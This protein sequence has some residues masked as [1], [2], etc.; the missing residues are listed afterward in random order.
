[1]TARLQAATSSGKPILLRVDFDAGHGFGSGR[2]QRNQLVADE[3]AFALWQ[4]GDP[5]QR[6]P[7]QAA[8]LLRSGLKERLSAT[9]GFGRL[10][11][12][13]CLSCNE[14]ETLRTRGLYRLIK[15]LAAHRRFRVSHKDFAQGERS[16]EIQSE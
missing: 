9:D 4:L 3:L 14:F 6:R 8:V 16:F 10:S 5:A 1:M 7:I 15:P 12:G 2:S 13:F 11:R